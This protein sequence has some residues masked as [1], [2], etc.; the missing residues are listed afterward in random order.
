MLLQ[1]PELMLLAEGVEEEISAGPRN[2]GLA[3]EEVRRRTAEVMQA[4]GLAGLASQA[5]LALSRGQRLRVAL[6]SIL[7]MTPRLL[8]LDEPTSG[9]DRSQIESM[10]DHLAGTLGERT[11]IFCT[12]DVLTAARYAHKVVV[13]A[14]GRVLVS[15]TPAEVF[16]ASEALEQAHLHPPLALDMAR[17]LGFPGVA[18]VDELVMCL[19]EAERKA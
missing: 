17:R 1:N 15:G 8:L 9:Q 10:M 11:V 14:G 3:P 13:L 12:H 5:P 7:S 16:S 18:S 6:A 4:L 2:L 19:R